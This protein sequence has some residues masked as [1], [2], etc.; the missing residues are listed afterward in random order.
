MRKI[1]VLFLLLFGAELS[2]DA[3]AEATVETSKQ[4]AANNWPVKKSF[5]SVSANAINYSLYG[6]NDHVVEGPAGKI[7]IG[8]GV[9]KENFF[10]FASA[11]LGL[12]PYA[13]KQRDLLVDFSSNG[14]TVMLGSPLKGLA[15]RDKFGSYG[16]LFGMSYEDVAGRSIGHKRRETTADEVL[17]ERYQLSFV[18]LSLLAGVFYAR[19]KEARPDVNEPESLKTRTEG[20]IVSLTSAFPTYAPYTAKYWPIGRTAMFPEVKESGKL[21]GYLVLLSFHV[22]LG[23]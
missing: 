20:W 12:G 18:T 11:D 19:F 2:V 13:V 9:V 5:W 4:A 10:A 21:S 7:S 22:L 16:V 23:G 8:Y 6:D 15:P 14:G 1:F 3:F 17:T